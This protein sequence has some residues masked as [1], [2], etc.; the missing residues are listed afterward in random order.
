MTSSLIHRKMGLVRPIVEKPL[1]MPEYEDS[2][3][4]LRLSLPLEVTRKL[5]GVVNPARRCSRRLRTIRGVV[6]AEYSCPVCH[7]HFFD[8][9]T[10]IRSFNATCGRWECMGK[11]RILYL[12]EYAPLTE[13]WADLVMQLYSKLRLDQSKDLY[14]PS[15]VIEYLRPQ[16]DELRRTRSGRVEL[17]LRTDKDGYDLH[18][19]R[20]VIRAEGDKND[21]SSFIIARGGLTRGKS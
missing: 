2:Y 15:R 1:Q 17:H 19:L 9:I 8:H 20:I 10:D 16:Y 14:E 21:R 6:C 5:L 3:T 11:D 13:A 7:R 4:K 18:D 12:H